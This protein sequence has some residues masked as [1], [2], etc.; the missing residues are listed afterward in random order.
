MQVCVAIELSV[1]RTRKHAQQVRSAAARMTD[2]QM[3]VRVRLPSRVPTQV[4]TEF[5]IPK[6]RQLDVVDRIAH[7]FWNVDDYGTCTIWFPKRERKT[8]RTRRATEPGP[9]LSVP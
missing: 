5:S 6:A 3:S 9:T 7:G 8:R 2:E 4:I 1:A